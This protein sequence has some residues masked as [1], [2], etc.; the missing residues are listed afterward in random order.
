M[1]AQNAR[2]HLCCDGK[3][4]EEGGDQL[5]GSMTLNMGPV[6]SHRYSR[7]Y[8]K[9]LLP[10]VSGF[11]PRS[12]SFRRPPRAPRALLF[13]LCPPSLSPHI[14]SVHTITGS[15][16]TIPVA[17]ASMGN[18]G[19]FPQSSGELHFHPVRGKLLS[20]PGEFILPQGVGKG[21]GGYMMCLYFC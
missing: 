19:C 15:E 5:P 12:F 2:C 18:W 3:R 14:C 11:L 21:G 13:H 17:S 16:K 20:W 7:W 9:S 4:R 8:T 6:L 10:P 1:W